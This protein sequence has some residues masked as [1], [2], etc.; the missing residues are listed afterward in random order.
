[1]LITPNYILQIRQRRNEILIDNN[2]ERVTK[3]K[4]EEEK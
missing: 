2:S 4:E 3:E 1:M